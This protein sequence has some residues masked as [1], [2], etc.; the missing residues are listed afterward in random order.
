MHSRKVR[1]IQDIPYGDKKVELH[2]ISKKYFNPSLDESLTIAEKFD[3]L[4]FTGRRTKRLENLLLNLTKEMSAIGV[5]R[6]IKRDVSDV[7][8]STIL[9][10]LKKINNYRYFYCKSGYS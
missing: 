8:D 4:G 7:S 9:R 5:E 6:T 1:V 10:I 2:L 3:F